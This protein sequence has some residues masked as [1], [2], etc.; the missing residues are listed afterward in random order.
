M[1]SDT[2]VENT[3]RKRICTPSLIFKDCYTSLTFGNLVQGETENF[4]E[5]QVSS[6]ST[7]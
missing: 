2:N 1:A 5:V 7:H 3:G 6:D 4:E